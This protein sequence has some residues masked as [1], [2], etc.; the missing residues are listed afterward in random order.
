M[1]SYNDLNGVPNHANKWLLKDVLR[2]EWGFEGYIIG[3]AGGVDELFMIQGVAKDKDEAA[4]LAI[5][6]G[7]DLDLVRHINTY[8]GLVDLVKTKRVD[9]KHV[10]RAVYNL[11]V[12]KFRMGLFENPYI[13]PE[14]VVYNTEEHKQ[15]ALEAALKS[16]VL[17]K[18]KDGVLPLNSSSL[19]S[20]A[21]IGPNAADV[22]LGGYTSDPHVV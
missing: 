10:D 22:H 8:R 16:I 4:K 12:L 3:D 19:K 14:K 2:K 1:A 5:E 17:L 13:D 20:I 9:I 11:L 15:L 7:I 21:V 6:A 18:N